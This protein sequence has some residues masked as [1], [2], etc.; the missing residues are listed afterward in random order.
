MIAVSFPKANN[1]DEWAKQLRAARVIVKCPD[2]MD[3]KAMC[4]WIK[5]GLDPDKQAEYW[6]KVKKRIEKLGPIPQHIFDADEYGK[7]TQ[8][9]M[10]ALEWINIG[11]QGKYF[12]LRGEEKLYSE[13]PSHKL[14][15]NFRART[16][17]GAEVF[18]N[19]SICADIGFR[20][21]DCLAKPLPRRIFC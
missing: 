11:D 7:R 8:G 2:K 13:D 16:D 20:T 4:A 1:C 9:V 12:T 5:R 3:V 15:K 21:A 6:K 17:E 14:V 18:L 10:R 19:A